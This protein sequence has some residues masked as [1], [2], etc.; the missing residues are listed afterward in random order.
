MP[1]TDIPSPDLEQLR[2]LVLEQQRHIESLNRRVSWLSRDGQPLD[3]ERTA[4]RRD[5][6][7]LAGLGVAGAAVGAVA[8]RP[9]GVAAADGANLVIG[10]N[11]NT[12]NQSS[13]TTE[14]DYTS[15]ASDT[16]SATV[17]RL[18]STQGSSATT[19]ITGFSA[20]GLG[21]GDGADISTD[22]G[23]GA[24]I[25]SSSGVDLKLS[26]TGRFNQLLG[27]GSAGATAP[28]YRGDTSFSLGGPPVPVA[29]EFVRG[30]AGEI[31][32]AK[33]QGAVASDS[34][35][36]AYWKRINALRFDAADGSGNFFTPVRVKDTRSG[37]PLTGGGTLNVQVAGVG[38]VPVDAIGVVGNLTAVTPNYTGFLTIFPTGGTNPALT[39]TPTSQV[40]FVNGTI[41]TPNAFICGLGSGQ[42]SVFANGPSSVHVHVLVDITGYIQ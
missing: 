31:W 7:R 25:S 36:Q 1:E 10:N 14:L 3:P 41:A 21:G 24:S 29:A 22:S 39:A 12:T 18:T 15:P 30:T 20:A 16:G 11:N 9:H 40:N 6:L 4:S 32:A 2:Q 23:T 17:L 42:V 13:H 37:S 8:L 35:A 34:N 27:P 5:L 26:G 28:N 38:G 33:F 19:T